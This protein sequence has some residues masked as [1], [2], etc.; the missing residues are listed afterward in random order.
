MEYR[1]IYSM[2]MVQSDGRKRLLEY[3]CLSWLLFRL[4]LSFTLQIYWLKIISKIYFA[5]DAFTFIPTFPYEYDVS[6]MSIYLDYMCVIIYIYVYRILYTS[7]RVSTVIKEGNVHLV[8]SKAMISIHAFAIVEQVVFSRA[9]VI[10]NC[11]CDIL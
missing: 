5:I 8:P 11:G 3:C 10:R 7:Y 2:D 9:L 4:L 6:E 1:L